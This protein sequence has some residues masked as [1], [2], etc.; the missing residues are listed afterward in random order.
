[1]A[2]LQAQLNEL[3]DQPE[4][5]PLELAE[6]TLPAL[7]WA[8]AD[9]AVSLALGSNPDIQEAQ[10]NI[11][12]ARAAVCAAKVDYLPNVAVIGGFSNQTFADYIQPDIGY[13]SVVGTYTFWDWGKR[14]NTVRER[15]NLVALATLKLQQTEDD[16]RQK[17][18]KAFREVEQDRETVKNAEEMVALRKEAQKK[19]ATPADQMA[20]AKAL[21]QASIDLIKA[22]MTYRVGYAH[23]LNETGTH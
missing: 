6:L 1:V 8:C 3:L 14:R 4:C 17:I 11:I 23:L 7:P 18:L 21:M 13:V 10:Q 9:D 16:V 15:Q 5:T 20:A 12:K 22:Q 19:A 2:D